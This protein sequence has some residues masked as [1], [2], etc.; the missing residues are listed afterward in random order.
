MAAIT[1][2][3]GRKLYFYPGNQS[4]DTSVQRLDMSLP[5]D[6]TII[7]AW[8]K[9]DPHPQ[10]LNLYV[11]D[12]VGIPQVKTSVPLV[13]DGD[14]EPDHGFFAKWMP[15][16]V[17]QA[18]IS[19]AAAPLAPTPAGADLNAAQAALTQPSNDPSEKS[20]AESVEQATQNPT[21]TA[22]SAMPI[23]TGSIQPQPI[24]PFTDFGGALKILRE[25]K[26]VTRDTWPV[27]VYVYL[28]GAARYPAQTGVAKKAFGENGMVPYMAYLAIKRADGNVS[29]YNPGMDSLL[30]E[31][32]KEA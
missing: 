5:L 29:V 1:P 15:F 8:P 30:A 12:H 28:V 31:D 6:A 27:S 14:I 25:G 17:S 19:Q 4:A 9:T 7:Y 20:S 22:T 23:E 18:Q 3:I 13:Q 2:T 32:W 16:Q 21:P 10:L 11:I 24:N 26:A